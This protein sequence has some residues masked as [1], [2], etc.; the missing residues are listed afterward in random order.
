MIRVSEVEESRIAW[1]RRCTYQ[2]PSQVTWKLPFPIM[3][4]GLGNEKLP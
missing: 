1:Q 4:K 3:I 2:V